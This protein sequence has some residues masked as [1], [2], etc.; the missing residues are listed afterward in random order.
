MRVLDKFILKSAPMGAV[1]AALTALA[2]WLKQ[3]LDVS[4]RLVKEQQELRA[5]VQQLQVN[6][7]TMMVWLHMQSQAQHAATALPNINGKQLPSASA[8]S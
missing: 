4:T 6:Q 2:T 3:L 1:G 8:P 5:T 7:H